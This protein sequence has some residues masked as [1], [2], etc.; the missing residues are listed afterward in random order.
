M[1][2]LQ[3]TVEKTLDQRIAALPRK[4]PKSI[5]IIKCNK[6]V[7]VGLTPP[8]TNSSTLEQHNEYF[9]R[10]NS[11]NIQVGM[12]FIDVMEACN[13]KVHYQNHLSNTTLL[14]TSTCLQYS[15]ISIHL[16]NIMSIVYEISI[17]SSNIMSILYEVNSQIQ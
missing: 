4:C 12:H 14:C 1:P 13:E 3:Y 17:H 16:S 11:S 2:L 9:V 7:Q 10:S 6:F 15:Q 5:I 8:F